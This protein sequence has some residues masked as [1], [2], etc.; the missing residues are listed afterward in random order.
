[1]PNHLTVWVT[2]NWKIL[3]ELEIPDHFL[4]P[5][6]EKSVCRSRSMEKLEPD[7][8]QE[9]GSELGKEYIK[10]VYCHPAYL[11]NMQS[12]SSKFWEG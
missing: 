4:R 7:M 1:M 5:P 9:T 2:K 11:T 8:E 10:N 6:P 12:I 3:K